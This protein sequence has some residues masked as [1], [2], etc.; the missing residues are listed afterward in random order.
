MAF[1]REILE[2]IDAVSGF[3]DTHDDESVME[4]MNDEATLKEK[5][6]Q[7]VKEAISVKD[8]L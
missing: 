3:I 8:G 4:Q 2:F 5:P 7:Q 1:A 6:S